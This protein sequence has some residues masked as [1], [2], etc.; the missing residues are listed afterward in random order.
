MTASEYIRQSIIAQLKADSIELIAE[1]SW[2]GVL[3]PDR[4]RAAA[5]DPLNSGS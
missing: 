5:G 2:S 3:R 4:N 1:R